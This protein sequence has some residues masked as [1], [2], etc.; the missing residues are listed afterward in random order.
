[1]LSCTCCFAVTEVLSSR[2]LTRVPQ[3][4]SENLV[5]LDLSDNNITEITIADFRTLKQ[6]KII[7]LSY[8]QIRTLYEGSFEHV[9]CLEE[10]D[11]SNNYIDH[12]P[13]SIFSSNKNLQKLYLKKNSLQAF[14]DLSKAQHILD[15]KSLIYLDISFCNITSISCESLIKGIPNLK[16][17][18]IDG[19]PL[20]QQN[21]EI[22]NPLK[23]LTTMKP[24]FCNSSIVE[25]FC[26]NLQEQ[27][28]EITSANI[29]LRTRQTEANGKDGIQT[30]VLVIGIILCVVVF[31]IVV[32]WYYLNIIC[33]HR[34]ANMVSIERHNSIITIPNGPLPPPPSP[35]GGYEIPKR[36]LPPPP[37]PNGGYEVPIIPK[38]E[39]TSSLT[40]NNLKLNR[41]CG[42]VRL[43]SAESDILINTHTDNYHVSLE[44]N[45]GSAHSLSGS[46]GYQDN[47]SGRPSV[48]IYSYSDLSEEGEEENNLP[49]PPKN[50]K[51]SISPSP[52]FLGANWPATTEIPTRT[53]QRLGCPQDGGY[54]EKMEVLTQPAP[55]SPASPTRNVT[56]F[57]VKK[58]NSKTVYVS[59]ISIEVG[60][61]L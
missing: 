8:N 55:T 60:H 51:S 37:F 33:T 24:D 13:H 58:I 61:D 39:C 18:K 17:L 31:I 32:S 20:T 52:H 7:N 36:P 11:L 54:L 59:S 44:S 16:E 27:A 19:N 30:F 3:N 22:E 43:P 10:L 56:T 25:K 46:T 42:Y 15:S 38:N 26:C 29:S 4:L 9:S 2:G 50:R 41:N 23:N 40:S 48:S 28:L 5:T 35:N 45:Q 14:G 1:M 53:H 21:V 47:I 57:S 49:V 6:V 12:L 34:K